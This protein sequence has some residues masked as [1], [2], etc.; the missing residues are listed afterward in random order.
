MG[1]LCG[2][3]AWLVTRLAVIHGLEEWMLDGCF[4]HRGPR[5]SA[6][7]VVLIGLDEASLDELH[8]PLAFASPELARVVSYA[9]EQGAAALGLDLIVPAS[10]SGLADLQEGKVGDPKRLGQAISDAG[11]V[12]LAQ[13]KAEGRWL[14]PLPQWRWKHEL[15]P[16]PTDLAFVD[17]SEDPDQFIRRQLL[18]ARDGDEP[19]YQF[20]L[21]LFA[22]ARGAPPKWDG[23]RLSVGDEAIPLDDR[24]QLRIN[25]VGPPGSFEVIPF[26]DALA[27]ADGGRPLA[28]D[29]RGAVVIVGVTA[30]SQ[31]D[32]HA[33][34]YSNNY[35]RG[36]VPRSTGLMS[37]PEIHAHTLAT[38]LDGAYLVPQPWLSSLPALL[39]LGGLFGIAFGQLNRLRGTVAFF[40]ATLALFL[41]LHFGWKYL[42]IE[43]FRTWNWQIDV[44]PVLFLGLFAYAGN[45]AVR[46]LTTRRILGMVKSRDVLEE[47]EAIAQPGLRGEE[48]VVTVLFADIRDFTP[49]SRAHAPQE[50]V[51]LLNAY[52]GAIVPVIEAHGGT[53]NQYMGDGI[54]VLFG[55]PKKVDDHALRAVRTAVAMIRR[56]HELKDEWAKHGAPGFRIGIGVHTGPVI[57]GTVGSPR[58]MDYTAI[59]D[60]VNAAARIEAEN[61]ASGTEVLI[62]EETYRHLPWEERRRLGCDPETRVANLKGIEEPLP[63]SAV[64]VPANGDPEGTPN[65]AEAPAGG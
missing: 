7:R 38:M 46:W 5:P 40:A 31:Q 17:V 59:G 28:A 51:A 11:N 19:V 8:K 25:F 29:L 43:C 4:F 54:M 10:M 16:E 62:S 23:S 39:A 14:L 63:L 34:P 56:V 12:V 65:G 37:G 45:F 44:L 9:K 1:L 22:R 33:T 15:Q 21:A 13:W 18:I 50:V 49:Y 36:F 53:L 52:F 27:A 35:W 47:L 24:Q 30:R 26:R 55:A 60:V 64:R 6:A 41:A 20:A 3:A 42:C 57:V 2:L 58:R 48:R 32:V 61:K